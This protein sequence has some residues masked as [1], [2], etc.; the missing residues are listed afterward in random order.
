MEW[1][2]WKKKPSPSPTLEEQADR[3]AVEIKKLELR[4]DLASNESSAWPSGFEGRFTGLR[5]AHAKREFSEVMQQI[6]ERRRPKNTVEADLAAARARLN[7][8]GPKDYRRQKVEPRIAELEQELQKAV[9]R[10]LQRPL[11]VYY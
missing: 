11:E 10:E 1:M 3:L 7:E 4:R 5:L 9:E 6:W 8:L 2:F